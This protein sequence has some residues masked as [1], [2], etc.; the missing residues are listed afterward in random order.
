MRIVRE[1]HLLRGQGA[2]LI[3]VVRTVEPVPTVKIRGA[4]RGVLQACMQ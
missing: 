4:N 1:L 2:Q 3:I